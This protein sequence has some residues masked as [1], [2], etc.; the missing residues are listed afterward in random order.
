MKRILV[1][2]LNSIAITAFLGSALI[3]A[4]STGP[5]PGHTG[6]FNEN[7]CHVCHL[8][9]PVNSGHATGGQFYVAGV[10]KSYNPGS[11]Y[12]VTVVISHPGQSRWGFQLSARFQE[13]GEQAGTLVPT[14]ENTLIQ[15]ANGIQY[16]SHTQVGTREGL[17]D[18]PVQFTF[19]WV[20]P[21][22]GSGPIFFNA[23]GNAANSSGDPLGDY[24]YTAGAYS[25]SA[26]G[27]P[28]VITP[29]TTVP[30]RR[31][32]RILS[33]SRFMHIPAP[34]DLNR[35]DMEIHIE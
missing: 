33:A 5:I 28:G 7:S 10:P 16:I 6:G 34:V 2:M 11:T 35:G 3:L 26:V 19:N 32:R 30:E 25:I 24:I 15:E 21:T 29:V 12:P 22:T 23:A 1:A 27:E 31:T 9:F 14:D 8:E 13:S 18:G 4:F 20:A 17:R